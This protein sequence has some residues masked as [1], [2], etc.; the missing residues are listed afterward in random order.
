METTAKEMSEAGREAANETMDNLK[1]KI[2]EGR[3][4]VKKYAGQAKQMAGDYAN[5]AGEIGK[6]AKHATEEK[7]KTMPIESMLV[8]LGVGA[9]V[10]MC[11]GLLFGKREQD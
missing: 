8:A 11:V 4:A 7:I 2:E 9:C 6:K 5:K 1:G 10:G 3:D